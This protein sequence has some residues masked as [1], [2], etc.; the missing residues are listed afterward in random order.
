MAGFFSD[1]DED[2]SR[3]KRKLKALRRKSWFNWQPVKMWRGNAQDPLVRRVLWKSLGDR[4]AYDPFSQL[5]PLRSISKDARPRVC[6]HQ[7]RK[8][9]FIKRE[10]LEVGMQSLKC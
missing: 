8:P 1:S 4:G 2:I 10:N 5:Q 3:T 7:V 6:F 9:R